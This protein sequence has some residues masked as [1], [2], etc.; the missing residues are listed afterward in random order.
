MGDRERQIERYRERD[1][2]GERG[3]FGD[4][5]RL[6]HLRPY[7]CGMRKRKKSC[8]WVVMMFKQ[9]VSWLSG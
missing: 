4:T 2:G 1:R 3:R 5:L 7:E 9:G 6:I 8:A